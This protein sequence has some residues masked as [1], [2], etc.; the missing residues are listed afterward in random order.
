MILRLTYWQSQLQNKIFH[1]KNLL[2]LELMNKSL[3]QA[4]YQAPSTNRDMLLN[5]EYRL[6]E[7]HKN[8]K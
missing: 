5:L 2:G 3:R 4:M 8:Q 7:K 6:F 1:Q